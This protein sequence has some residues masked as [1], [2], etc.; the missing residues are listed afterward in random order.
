MN[1]PKQRRFTVAPTLHYFTL[2]ELLVVITIISILAGMLLPALAKA[3][4]KARQMQCM[5]N[6]KQMHQAFIQYVD[7]NREAPPYYDTASGS[8]WTSFL[9][10][11]YITQPGSGKIMPKCAKGGILICPNTQADPYCP[12]RNDLYK[13]R[14]QTYC[15]NVAAGGGPFGHWRRMSRHSETL[16]FCDT[17]TMNGQYYRVNSFS[18]LAKNNPPI[19]TDRHFTGL[20]IVFCDGH[21]EWHKGYMPVPLP[22]DKDDWPWFENQY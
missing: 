4:N 13:W 12:D 2:V 20:D 15:M 11:Q 9:S 14:Y 16:L 7:D 10:P 19:L 8:I 17:G 21:A 18:L 22:T 1:K 5:N 3:V 6:L